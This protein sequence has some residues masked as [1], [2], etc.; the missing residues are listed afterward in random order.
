MAA[1][2]DVTPKTIRN[3]KKKFGFKLVTKPKCHA[4]TNRTIEIRRKRAYGLYRMLNKDRWKRVVTSDEAWIYLQHVNGKRNVQYLAVNQRRSEAEV[5]VHVSHPKGVMVWVGFC[6][7]GILKPIFV[8]PGAKINAQ[9]YISHVLK[10]FL[11]DVKKFF[12][13]NDYIF[14]QDSAPHEIDDR[15][16]RP[17]QSSIHQT[18]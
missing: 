2:L 11:K 1:A 15:I 16:L 4:L 5:Q 18:S 12:P 10:P 7:K 13:K 17:E 3:Y 6:S 8:E 9:Y 14:Q